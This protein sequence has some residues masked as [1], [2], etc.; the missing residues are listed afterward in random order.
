MAT[1]R[2]A[3][4][5]QRQEGIVPVSPAAAR[6][7]GN[8]PD[9]W[10]HEYSRKRPLRLLHPD[11][12]LE[13]ETQ[14]ASGEKVGQGQPRTRWDKSK[15]DLRC[16]SWNQRMGN[17]GIW[18][19]QRPDVGEQSMVWRPDM[20]PLSRSYQLQDSRERPCPEKGHMSSPPR[21]QHNGAGSALRWGDA[22]RGSS[23]PF[24]SPRLSKKKLD[25]S[26]LEGRSG[27]QRQGSLDSNVERPAF[28]RRGSNLSNHSRSPSS[29]RTDGRPR[30]PVDAWSI[31]D[32]HDNRN[33]NSFRGEPERQRNFGLRQMDKRSQSV[34]PDAQPGIS[35]SQQA[36]TKSFA[37]RAFLHADSSDRYEK[38]AQKQPSGD[39]KTVKKESHHGK[40]L[41]QHDRNAQ[42]EKYVRDEPLDQTTMNT[43][44]KET[45]KGEEKRIHHGNDARHQDRY[46][47]GV[48]QQT[49][50]RT[51]AE[52]QKK[53]AIVS[54]L[55]ACVD[56]KRNSL[57][58]NIKDTPTPQLT[59]SCTGT[60]LITSFS[61]S[62]CSQSAIGIESP[63]SLTHT[64]D[65]H[66][67]TATADTRDVDLKETF[68]Q[69]NETVV[70]M[71]N[72]SL[73]HI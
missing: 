35:S 60:S 47:Y 1:F 52:R 48:K 71:T 67:D 27:F 44:V 56:M 22:S 65:E 59:E 28:H 45:V 17:D 34:G 61:Y 42:Y 30:R 62:S 4:F 33:K 69:L 3:P 19:R 49:Q 7:G 5:R 72:L 66:K 31:H 50:P 43:G 11:E 2:P 54:K 16:H 41:E 57:K 55:P 39:D 9:K 63:H 73:I 58:D 23:M 38:H 64:E 14:R 68:A 70:S 40:D 36:S 29:S 32:S 13:N 10:E 18:E 25:S 8:A 21:K 15:P 46:S 24:P 51:V 6:D 26:R 53:A 20:R 37:E 12:R